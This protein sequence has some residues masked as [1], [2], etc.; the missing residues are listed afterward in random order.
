MKE[1]RKGFSLTLR[2]GVINDECLSYYLTADIRA[3]ASCSWLCSCCEL[4]LVVKIQAFKKR[5]RK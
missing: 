5:F 1:G 2:L 4:C 3:K